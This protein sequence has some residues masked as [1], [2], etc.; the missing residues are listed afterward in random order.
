[1]CG[2]DELV[3]P[4]GVSSLSSWG[5]TGQVKTWTWWP[6]RERAVCKVWAWRSMPPG[7]VP[8]GHF[9]ENT[10]ILRETGLGRSRGKERRFQANSAVRRSPDQ[11]LGRVEKVVQREVVVGVWRR[12]RAGMVKRTTKK[13]VVQRFD[14]E[15]EMGFLGL[16]MLGAIFCLEL[17]GER[18]KNGGGGGRWMFGLCFEFYNLYCCMGKWGRC[19]RTK[20]S[21]STGWNFFE[22][23]SHAAFLRK[24]NIHV[25]YA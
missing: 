25:P 6:R 17:S 23:V 11:G 18:Q 5:R 24:K 10:A 4:C 19:P 9:L 3:L 7:T 1:M 8:I 16:I 22:C 13:R 2:D 15:E 12:K 14:W 21:T 20:A